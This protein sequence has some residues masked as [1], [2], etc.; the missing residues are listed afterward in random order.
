M[1]FRILFLLFF[2]CTGFRAISQ[3]DAIPEIHILF[4]HKEAKTG[5]FLYRKSMPENISL[6]AMGTNS[7]RKRA[8]TECTFTVS[9]IELILRN[10]KNQVKYTQKI[11]GQADISEMLSKIGTYDV[12]TIKIRTIHRKKATGQDFFYPLYRQ[13][14]FTV[15]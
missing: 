9:D 2:Y 11:S 5:T 10:S 13:S 3:S 14:S 12:L 7:Y 15:R 4:D 1:S 6:L 8:P